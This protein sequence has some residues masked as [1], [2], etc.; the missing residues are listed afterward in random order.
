MLGSMDSDVEA[1]EE[2]RAGADRGPEGGAAPLAREPA[3]GAGGGGIWDEE[4]PAWL[5]P[6]WM[7]CL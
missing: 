3:D 2:G 7:L 4:G 6:F 5:L 1:E